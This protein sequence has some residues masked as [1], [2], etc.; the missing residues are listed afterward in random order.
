MYVHTCM[1]AQMH[2]CVYLDINASHIEEC[3]L[4]FFC[5]IIGNIFKKTKGKWFKKQMLGLME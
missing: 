4:L 3:F 5:E 1:C 2:V